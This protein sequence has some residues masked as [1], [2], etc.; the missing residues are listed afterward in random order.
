MMGR[1]L[2]HAQNWL[3]LTHRRLANSLRVASQSE[4][5]FSYDIKFHIYNISTNNN[6]HHQHRI[7][8][9]HIKHIKFR[10]PLCL[11]KI[12]QRVKITNTC[13]VN[14]FFI[15]RWYLTDWNECSK[16]CGNGS[17]SR[18]LYCRKQ[19]NDS[20]YEELDESACNIST[21]PKVSLFQRCNEMLC[22]AEW[23]SLPWSEVKI[24]RLII[25]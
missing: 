17:H 13:E 22:P 21:K 20:Y 10:T 3:N 15:L 19:I 11:I 2:T 12:L 18:L 24:H 9:K 5:T 8:I 25:K 1:L 14:L 16:T 4:F 23:I 7:S 6:K